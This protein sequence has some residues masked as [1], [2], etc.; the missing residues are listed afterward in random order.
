VQII[1]DIFTDQH[2]LGAMLATIVFIVLGY[3]L[4]RLGLI[5]Q[6]GKKAISASSMRRK[7]ISRKTNTTKPHTH[8]I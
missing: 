2:F 7:E 4:S 3:V 6:D 5:K 8:P 1:K